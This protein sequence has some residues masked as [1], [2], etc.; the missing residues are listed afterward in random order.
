M[1][2]TMTANM[3]RLSESEVIVVRGILK[4]LEEELVAELRDN[5]R[6]TEYTKRRYEALINQNRSTIGGTYKT[7]EANHQAF[8]ENVA[9]LGGKGTANVFASIGIPLDSVALTTEQ[10]KSL[11]SNALIEGAPSRAWWAKQDANLR[12]SFAQQMRIGYASGETV[13]QLVQRVRGTATGV[14]SAYLVDGQ[15]KWYHEFEGGIMDTGTRQAQA[16][17]RTSVQQISSDAKMAVFQANADI[18]KGVTWVSTLDSRTTLL[19]ASRDGLMWDL[20]GKPIGHDL[21]FLGGPP[22]HWGC[23]ST[24][25]PVTKSFEEMGASP[26]IDKAYTEALSP[27]TRASLQGDV[28]EAT[29]FDDWFGDQSEADQRAYL[30]QTKYSI[31]KEKGLTM[32]QMADQFGNPLTVEQLARE[33]GW[34]TSPPPP[35]TIDWSSAAKDEAAHSA[36]AISSVLSELEK[37]AI[38]D[39]TEEYFTKV[40]R[41]L[42]TKGGLEAADEEIQDCIKHI[43][44]VFKKSSGVTENII[45]YR[46]AGVSVDQ[47]VPE[48]ILRDFMKNTSVPSNEFVLPAFTSTSSSARKAATFGDGVFFEIRVPKGKKALSIRELSDLP[49]ENEILL[50]SGSKFRI[51]EIRGGTV[52]P[53]VGTVNNYIV[54]ELQ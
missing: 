13:D 23:R 50:N 53:G 7:I 31:W 54:L 34:G 45:V 42:F 25:A 40:N 17:V 19:C 32:A 5:P 26:E 48:H 44:E 2:V 28:P 6:L 47:M 51:I 20:E 41:A 4:Q 1:F 33:Y 46:G 21:P 12:D 22:A 8:L 52:V 18:L 39:Y 15:T 36:A 37:Q 14:K 27:G 38:K 35:P 29:T 30:G 10:L 3:Q 49:R 24:L 9:G 43:Q 11:A 16:L